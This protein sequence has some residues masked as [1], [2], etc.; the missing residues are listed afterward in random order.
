MESINVGEF[1][2]RFSEILDRVKAGEEIII[3][4][5]KKRKRVAVI[6]P[7]SMYT[8]KKERELGLLKDRGAFVIHD[9]F[10]MTDE[11]MLQS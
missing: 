8:T 3:S 10:R 6:V 5:G 1:K 11:E 7:Y 2:S 9:D 4:Y